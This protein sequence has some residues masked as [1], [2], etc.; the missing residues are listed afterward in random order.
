MV[1]IQQ[2]VQS[3]ACG[4]TDTHRKYIDPPPIVALQSSDPSH[5][6]DYSA[7]PFLLV[8]VS[9]WSDEHRRPLNRVTKVSDG[10]EFNQKQALCGTTA[11]GFDTLQGIDGQRGQFCFFPDLSVRVEGTFRLRFKLISAIEQYV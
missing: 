6:I 11:A 10:V 5:P 8:V 1:I 3:K 7:S 4:W 9:L 2:P